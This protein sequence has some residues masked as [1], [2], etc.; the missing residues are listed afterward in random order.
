[1]ETARIDLFEAVL[2]DPEYGQKFLDV[3][4]PQ[5]RDR[6]AALRA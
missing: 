3:R 5:M 1:L 2:A 6:L 4:Y